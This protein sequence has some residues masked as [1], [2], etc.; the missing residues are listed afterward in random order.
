MQMRTS[1]SAARADIANMLA[2]RDAIT[3]SHEKARGVK[4]GAIQPLP[5]I[6]DQQVP[7][8]REILHRQNDYAVC[9]RHKG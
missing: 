6:N 7:L 1:C 9:G 2:L 4:E 8:K 3:L 5:V